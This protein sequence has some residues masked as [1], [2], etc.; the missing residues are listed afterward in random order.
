MGA[1]YRA[2]DRMTG[3]PAAVKV[4]TGGTSLHDRFAQEARVLSELNHPSI[5]RYVAHGTTSHGELFLAMEWLE[6]ED[7]AQRLGRGGLTRAQTLCGVRRVAEGLGVAH[8]RGVVHRDVK[9]S[10]VLLPEGE[11]ARA[12]LVDF[13]IARLEASGVAP[14]SRPTTRTGMVLGTVGYMSPEQAIGAKDVD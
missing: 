3:A 7:L 10:N 5:V 2:L 14:A 6:G 1:V 13:G 11:P 12:K 4:L 9:P 8:A